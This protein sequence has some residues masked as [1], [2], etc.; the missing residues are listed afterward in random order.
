MERVM[1][2]VLR[3]I[4]SSCSLK[5]QQLLDRYLEFMGNTVD[6][7]E[8]LSCDLIGVMCN[9]FHYNVVRIG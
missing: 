5:R 7:G 8:K 6:E 2:A 4:M 9:M 3:K 1:R